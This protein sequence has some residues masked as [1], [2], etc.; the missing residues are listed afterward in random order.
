VS[1]R[2]QVNGGAEFYVQPSITNSVTELN[3]EL[4]NAVKKYNH[5]R[6]HH[7]LKCY[8]PIEYI[9]HHYLGDKKS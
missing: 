2:I 4:K 7:A 1:E 6:L 9:N 5:Y 3:L 8:T